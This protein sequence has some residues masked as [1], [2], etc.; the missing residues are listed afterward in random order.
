MGVLSK[1]TRKPAGEKVEK[2]P[3][4]SSPEEKMKGKTVEK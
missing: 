4:R 2:G 1:K 3:T